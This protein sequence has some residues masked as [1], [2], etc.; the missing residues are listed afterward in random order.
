MSWATKQKLASSLKAAPTLPCFFFCPHINVDLFFSSVC[1]VNKRK[2][3]Q[4]HSVIAAHVVVEGGI[5]GVSSIPEWVSEW[6]S[7]QAQ[8]AICSPQA[9]VCE[10][11]EKR[12][13]VLIF[14]TADILRCN[15]DCKSWD[16]NN[17]LRMAAF[18]WAASVSGSLCCIVCILFVQHSRTITI[19]ILCSSYCDI[20]N[21]CCFPIICA[22]WQ[23]YF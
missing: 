12:K 16:V 20:Q 18:C 22:K 14:F 5:V 2:H 15:L 11:W 3:G 10:L 1:G 6:V 21:V 19:V 13:T 9:A 4:R 17:K 7:V 8:N 23:S